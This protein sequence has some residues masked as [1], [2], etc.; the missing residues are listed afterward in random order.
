MTMDWA[1]GYVAEISYTYGFYRELTPSVLDFAVGVAGHRAPKVLHYCELGC[2]QGYS[3]NLLAAANPH[4]QFHA[5]DFNPAQVA[6]AQDLAA[7]AGNT[8]IKFYEDS[9]AEF[10]LR[11]DLP[12]FDVITLHGIYS[13]ISAENR[14]LIVDF[15]RRRL[16]PGGLVYVSYNALPG[17]AAAMPLRRLL[18]DGVA[19]AGDQPILH[20]LDKALGL[21]ERVADAGARFFT[22]NPG[23]KERLDKVKGQ[24]RAYLAHEYLNRDWTPFYHADVAA[25][26][27]GAKLNW[28]TS[29]HLL[30]RLDVIN[31]TDAQQKLLA[32]MP[33]GTRR[34]TLRDFMINQQF[35]RDV[36]VKGAVRLPPNRNQEDWKGRRFVLA[37][38][39]QSV[40]MNVQ[41]VVGEVTLQED[42]YRP[43][44]D[45]LD[46]DKAVGFDALL[47]HPALASLGALRLQQALIL[48]VGL[49]HVHPALPE[50]G[51]AE[52]QQRC[53]AFNDAVMN[54]ALWSSDLS[55]L[56]SPV[57]GG[58]I[59]ADQIAQLFLRAVL[60]GEADP[61][62]SAWSTLSRN[63]QRLV[64]DGKALSTETENLTELR[65]RFDNF[66]TG[67][68]PLFKRLG[69]L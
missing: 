12:D 69:I 21:V 47:A 17:W 5:T 28:V 2:G 60:S 40:V 46:T 29:A 35:R 27:A 52:R 31:L 33:E 15:I 63:G 51:G 44:L 66:Q 56:A 68:V 32:D 3:A 20:R 36:F 50:E 45:V 16:R 10:A 26:M 55:Y 8:N 59:P 9:F 64:R 1:A 30:E 41:G 6:G 65:Q 23:M 48:L 38:D 25:E 24:P 43:L 19:G 22:A 18:T 7:D 39:R 67:T 58:G 42:V 57:A 62:A 14:A 13:W 53:R 49:G 11:D 37:V 61:M 34:E 4:I 54:R